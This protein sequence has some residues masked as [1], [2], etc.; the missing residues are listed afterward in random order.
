MATTPAT[1]R[2]PIQP[3]AGMHFGLTGLAVMGQNLVRNIASRGFPI[4][5][6]NRTTEK[7][8]TF[9]QEHGGEGEIVAGRSVEEFVGALERPARVM[10]M[11]K[12]GSPV[13]AVLAELLPHLE[14][15]DVVIDG[16]NSE[17][18][19]TARRLDELA[20]H[21]ILYL[22]SGVSGGEEGALHGPSLMPGGTRAA[23][24]LIEP[25]FTRIAAQV[26]GTP[27]CTYIGDGGAGHYVK[28]VHNGIEYADM[29]LIAESY[30]LLHNGLGL[31]NDALHDVF[32]EWN[33]GELDSFLIQI[34]AEVFAAQGRRRR[35]IPHRQGARHGRA[36]GHRPAHRA[37]GAG[38]RRAAHRD[39]RSGV[40]ALVVGVEGRPGRGIEGAARP[41]RHRRV[42][43]H[44]GRRARRAV[45]VEDRRVRARVRSAA[46][47][48]GRVRLEPRPRRARDDLARW[49]HHPCPLPRPHQGG[50]RQRAAEEPHA[51]AVLH[52][53]ARRPRN[54]V[55][56]APSR[57]R[58]APASRRPRTRRHWRGTTAT[59]ARACPPT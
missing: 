42:A 10:I 47:R 37:V 27:C 3:G 29:Q 57:K 46:T 1:S 53:A 26:D 43:T 36:E 41:G 39:H 13:D 52:R 35:R 17:W 9:V 6:H 14:P 30:D 5:V 23:Y 20:R 21:D 25:V 33:A 8:D 31:D 11:V 50:V 7:T 51:R 24:D 34:T 49:L 38:A 2:S 56:G 59:A 40:R 54:P 4:A 58:S 44:Q 19:D 15:G 16:G 22:G 48:V 55:G 18:T 32:S 28:M 12:A 45:R